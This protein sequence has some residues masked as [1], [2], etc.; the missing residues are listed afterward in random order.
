[1]MEKLEGI[2]GWTTNLKNNN[3]NEELKFEEISDKS[4]QYINFLKSEFF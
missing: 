3:N 2:I 1:M 4:K